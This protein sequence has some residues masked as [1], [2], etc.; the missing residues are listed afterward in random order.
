MITI[1]VR[2][3][4]D[5]DLEVPLKDEKSIVRVVRLRRRFEW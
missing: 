3:D 1:I 4:E 2:A 5:A